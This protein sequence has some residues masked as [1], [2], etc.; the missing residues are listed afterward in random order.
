M[1]K[2]TMTL[3][4]VVQMI[5]ELKEVFKF[6]EKVI[7]LLQDL[8]EF[9][10]DVV[11]LLEEINDRIAESTAKMP[12]ASSKIDSVTSATEM[13]TTEILDRVDA[14][15]ASLNEIENK[16]QQIENARSEKQKIF[17]QILEEASL[18]EKGKELVERFKALSVCDN[19]LFEVR[20]KIKGINNETYN[21]TLALQVQDITA[22]QLA[23]VNHLIINVHEKLSKL[24]NNIH[25]SHFETTPEFSAKL[26]APEKTTFDPEA[27]YDTSSARQDEIDKLI[28]DQ[29]KGGGGT[30]SQDEI[31]KLFSG[32]NNG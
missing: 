17:A 15:S 1:E 23:A 11:P 14:I 7:P 2:V 27:K 18:T 16:L 31:D 32:E 5:T 28:A 21:I 22:Q 24:I 29:Q 30:A 9:M 3:T 19:A 20:E 13:A 6:T 12:T 25:S 4:Q 8:V 10:R 26:D